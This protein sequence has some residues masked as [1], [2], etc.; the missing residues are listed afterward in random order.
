MSKYDDIINLPHYESK[1]RK[2]MSMEQRAAQFAPFAALTG[3][4][5][6]IA[7]TARQTREKPELSAVECEEL[8]RKLNYA[9][10]NDT[11][12]RI[13]YF[14]S[15]QFKSGGSLKSITGKIGGIIETEGIIVMNDKRRVAAG[16]VINIEILIN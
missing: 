8:S 10:E 5:D 1:T 16:D 2:R 3:H 11:Y 12:V 4:S 15:D 14:A 9:L 13:T 6:A 7:E